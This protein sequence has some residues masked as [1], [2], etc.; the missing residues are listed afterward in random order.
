VDELDERHVVGRVPRADGLAR[1]PVDAP[2]R[3]RVVAAHLGLHRER[4]WEQR[5]E[6]RGEERYTERGEE[7]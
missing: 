3:Q 5:W 6:E 4:R 2:P 1:R 7:R